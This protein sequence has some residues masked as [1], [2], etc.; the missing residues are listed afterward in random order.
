MYDKHFRVINKQNKAFKDYRIIIFF[1]SFLKNGTYLC[2]SICTYHYSQASNMILTLSTNLNFLFSEV[3]S[4]SCWILISCS[5][6][7][8]FSY[9]GK[10]KKDFFFCFLQSHKIFKKKVLSVRTD[11]LDEIIV[12]EFHEAAQLR[13]T[14]NT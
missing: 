4:N 11:F 13:N 7:V 12:K 5:F 10:R 1:F 6:Q 8:L 2:L 3:S 9:V 14:I